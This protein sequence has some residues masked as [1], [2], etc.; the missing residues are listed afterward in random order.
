MA[1]ELGWKAREVDL[2]TLHSSTST[3][4]TLAKMKFKP[5][6]TNTSPPPPTKSSSGEVE[7]VSLVV[8]VSSVFHS[9]LTMSVWSK[10]VSAVP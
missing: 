5:A 6:P 7:N 1:I 4:P 2:R 3:T 9:L 10:L 8:S